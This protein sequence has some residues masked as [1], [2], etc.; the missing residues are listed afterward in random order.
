M[1][2]AAGASPAAKAMLGNGMRGNPGWSLW[3]Y[4][5]TGAGEVGTAV[6]RPRLSRRAATAAT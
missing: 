6:V 2:D 1:R 4:F 3:S 5:P